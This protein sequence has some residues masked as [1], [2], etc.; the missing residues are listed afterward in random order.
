MWNDLAGLLQLEMPLE[1]ANAA[2]TT[3]MRSLLKPRGRVFEVDV[4]VKEPTLSTFP[5]IHYSYAFR[6]TSPS[7]SLV[8]C[9]I[10]NST[11]M[12]DPGERPPQHG[13]NCQ[14]HLTL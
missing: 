2:G 6:S 8:A 11:A 4:A 13:S 5:G 7:C 3:G 14:K 10:L 12:D 9:Q 1:H